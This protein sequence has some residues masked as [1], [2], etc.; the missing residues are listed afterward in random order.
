[1]RA[2]M[3]EQFDDTQ[4]NASVFFNDEEFHKVL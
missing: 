2:K 1:M 3:L 4:S